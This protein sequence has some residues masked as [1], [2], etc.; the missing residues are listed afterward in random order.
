MDGY[1][2]HGICDFCDGGKMDNCP[3]CRGLGGV[4]ETYNAHGRLVE[5]SFCRHGTSKVSPLPKAPPV[6]GQEVRK[7]ACGT[8]LCWDEKEVCTN[9]VLRKKWRDNAKR[10]SRN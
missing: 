5:E 4:R 6:E 2:V 10:T 9:C 7:C 8:M 1:T 3:Y